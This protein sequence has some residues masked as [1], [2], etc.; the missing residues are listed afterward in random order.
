MSYTKEN[1]RLGNQIF[2]N[3][4]VSI[5]SEKY[6]LYVEY[7][8]Y[9]LIQKIGIDLFVGNKKYNETIK[10]TDDNYF[11]ILEKDTFYFNIDANDNYFQTKKISDML[12]SYINS[13]KIINHIINNNKYKERYNNNNDCFIHIRLGDVMK[14]NPGFEYYDSI[15]SKL[16]VD[17]IYIATDSPDHDIITNLKNKYSNIV[18]MG[19]ELYEIIIFGSTNKY[20]ILSYGTFSAIIGYLSFYSQVYYK[21]FCENY[22]WDW[23]SQ[24]ECDVFRNHCNKLGP[25][26]EV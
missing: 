6:D 5:I 24:N 22:A 21:T 14:W 3:L 16:Y 7:S 12:Y 23:D 15:I 8:N 10:V 4:A 1:G 19:D 11:E 18:M 26:I 20:V 17:N 13:D 9:S 2:R 25:W